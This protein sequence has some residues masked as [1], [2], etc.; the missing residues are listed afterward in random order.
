MRFLT[1][2]FVLIVFIRTV[3]YGLFEIKNEDNKIGGIAV[4][5]VAFAGLIF[6]NVF[7]WFR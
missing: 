1:F 6:P 5:A 4:I 7:L 3:S 2:I